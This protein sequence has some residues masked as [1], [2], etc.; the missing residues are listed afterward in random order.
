M[1]DPDAQSQEI[2][3]IKRMVTGFDRL[4][5]GIDFADYNALRFYNGKRAE[6][7]LPREDLPL[8]LLTK[9]QLDLVEDLLIGIEARGIA[10]D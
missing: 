10:G 4:G 3:R 5:E 1:T 6:W 2:E 7:N 9:A 8:T